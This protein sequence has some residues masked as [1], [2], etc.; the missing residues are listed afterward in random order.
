MWPVLA[1][2][3]G[4]LAAL[5]IPER[6][7]RERRVGPP[8]AALLGETLTLSDPG[9]APVNNSVLDPGEKDKLVLGIYKIE[10][11]VLTLAER[12]PGLKDRP[13]EFK[14]SDRN[15]MVTV[16]HRVAARK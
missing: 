3:Y 4:G 1:R 6:V 12:R 9:P 15:T 2:V 7:R 11:D 16:Y 13:T 14:S 8:S 10:G 5:Q